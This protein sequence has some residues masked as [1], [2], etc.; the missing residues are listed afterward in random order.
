MLCHGSY[1]GESNG[2]VLKE[3]VNLDKKYVNETCL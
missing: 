1:G 2:I 3:I